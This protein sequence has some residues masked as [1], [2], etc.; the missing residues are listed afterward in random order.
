MFGVGLELVRRVVEHGAFEAHFAD[1]LAAAEEGRHR[2]EVL[3]PPNA[4]VPVG[5]HILCP[6]VEIAADGGDVDR[7]VRHRLRAVDQGRD[8]APA[9]SR[10]ISRTGLM[11][12][13]T[14]DTWVT[15]SSFV[16]RHR[17]NSASRSSVPSSRMSATLIL[18]PVRCATSCHGTMLAWCSMRVSRMESPGFSRGKGHEYA[19]RLIAKV[20]PLLGRCRRRARW[21]RRR[22]CR[23]PRRPRSPRP[24]ARARRLTLAIVGDGRNQSTALITVAGFWAGVRRIQVHQRL[25]RGPRAAAA[26]N[27]RGSRSSRRWVGLMRRSRRQRSSAASSGAQRLVVDAGDDLARQ[28]A[29]VSNRRASVSGFRAS[30]GGNSAVASSW[31]TVAHARPSLR[32]R[33]SSTG[34]CSI[35]ACS[36]NS[37]FLFD[38]SASLP[39]APARIDAAMEHRART[40]R[41][42]AAPDSE[43]P[44][45]RAILDAEAGIGR[46]VAVAQQHAIG[47]SIR[48]LALEGARSVRAATARGAS[49]VESLVL[50][51]AREHR[52][53]SARTRACATCACCG[54][55]QPLP[56]GWPDMRSALPRPAWSPG[57]WV[58]R[59]RGR[60]V[61]Q[62]IEMAQVAAK[63]G[64]RRA[65]TTRDERGVS[66]DSRRPVDA[67]EPS[68]TSAAL[69]A[70][71]S[72]AAWRRCMKLAARG[73]VASATGRL[74][75]RPSRQR[76]DRSLSAASNA[77][78]EH[79]ARRRDRSQRRHGAS[80]N[81]RG[82]CASAGDEARRSARA[83]GVS[84]VRCAGGRPSRNASSARRGG[85]VAVETGRGE[86]S[87]AL[88]IKP[89]F[90]GRCRSFTQA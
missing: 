27:R 81:A 20:V 65:P 56:R 47:C 79:H 75:G 84:S 15:P 7:H 24:R 50:R 57:R 38:N 62:V 5:P 88:I 45:S 72:S 60:A 67:D 86:S 58:R 78:D 37:R 87:R 49:S 36:D 52:V 44:V 71:T 74:L 53:G 26:G 40:P 16:R 51:L 77:V 22:A 10:Q 82:A 1:H 35:S 14:F 59:V 85:V 23:A 8:A 46:G 73:S 68:A 18:A 30:A 41:R 69:A 61:A 42:E 28:N 54:R 64:I 89:P 12:P 25:C 13:G 48:A 80:G 6:V 55:A 29:A 70:D 83:A 2:L 31:P 3:A 39:S 19:A 76:A 21:R 34:C 66:R 9:P 17:L 63:D 4:P 32:R 90:P 43:Q 33:G 11:V